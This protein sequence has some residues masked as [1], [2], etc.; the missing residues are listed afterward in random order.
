M[1]SKYAGFMAVI[2]FILLVLILTLVVA[3]EFCLPIDVPMEFWTGFHAWFLCHKLHSLVWIIY[4]PLLH[5]LLYGS[6]FPW[7]T[8]I[9]CTLPIP[10]GFVGVWSVHFFVT[11]GPV[12][13]SCS[14]FPLTIPVPFL[15]SPY[16]LVLSCVTGPPLGRHI[17]HPDQ[18]TYTEFVYEYAQ[19][20]CQ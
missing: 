8:K 1:N 6:T 4:F 7:P 20:W 5:I 15:C 14:P 9:F 18:Y 12:P 17:T 2:M 3:H 11:L 19:C 16:N 13:H 10:Y